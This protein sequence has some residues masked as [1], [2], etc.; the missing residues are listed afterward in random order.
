MDKLDQLLAQH[1]A[2]AL[3]G[4]KPANL[5]ACSRREFPQLEAHLARL[6]PL[7]ASKGIQMRIVCGCEKRQLLLVYRPA[8]LSAHLSRPEVQP[9]L[10][11]AGYQEEAP[12]DVQLAQLSQRFSASGFPHEIGLF[13]G[14]PP[15]DVAG[16]CQHRGQHCKYAGQWKVYGDVDRAK[17]LFQRYD[18]CRAAV[19]RRVAQGWSI[20]QIF[21]A[22]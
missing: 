18:R 11:K 19:C 4:I 12:L 14:Y 7:L 3:A 6:A 17:A 13:L 15:E 5:V 9:L 16:F 1:C 21:C 10:R 8:L 2:P 22:A 20:A